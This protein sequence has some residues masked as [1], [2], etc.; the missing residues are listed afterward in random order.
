M[1][2]YERRGNFGGSCLLGS[3]ESPLLLNW[4]QLPPS[5]HEIHSFFLFL[6]VF[7]WQSG[8]SL[9]GALCENRRRKLFWLELSLES[10]GRA[11][12]HLELRTPPSAMSA[13]EMLQTHRYCGILVEKEG[14]S[15]A[16]KKK[17]RKENVMEWG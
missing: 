5:K 9:N 11:T 6:T 16:L 13:N 10:F 15:Y 12:V 14:N 3:I 2:S 4:Q 7:Y 1:V 8:D 17:K